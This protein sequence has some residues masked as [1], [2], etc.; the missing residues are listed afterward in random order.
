MRL[1]SQRAKTWWMAALSPGTSLTRRGSVVTI[2]RV[3]VA[4]WCASPNLP[5]AEKLSKRRVPRVRRVGPYE[6]S[7]SVW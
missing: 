1:G 2:L 7:G 4:L 5:F 3:W 6:G